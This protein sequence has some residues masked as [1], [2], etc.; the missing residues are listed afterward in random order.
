MGYLY[1]LVEEG[2]V[3]RHFCC[4]SDE[5]ESQPTK[6]ADVQ[7]VAGIDE[8]P[9]KVIRGRDL[10]NA[11]CHQCPRATGLLIEEYPRSY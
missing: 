6:P 5:G 2:T 10:G 1:E 4:G 11:R 7:V 3:N 9:N 8:V